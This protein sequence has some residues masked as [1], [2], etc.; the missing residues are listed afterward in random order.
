MWPF[1]KKDEPEAV[2]ED[3]R[4]KEKPALLLFEIFVLDVIGRLS[5]EKRQGIQELDIQK[6]FSTK[7]GHWK[8]ALK[9]V[10]QLSTTIETAILN[11]WYEKLDE[12]GGTDEDI[13][14]EEFSREFADRYFSEGSQVDTWPEGGLEK[15]K[16]RIAEYKKKGL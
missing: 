1:G 2:F 9:E 12:N 15:A 3:P 4:Y 6:I 11:S 5:P 16:E 8:S 7:S 10:L 13:N 14:P